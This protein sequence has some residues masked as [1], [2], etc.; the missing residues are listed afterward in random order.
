MNKVSII[1]PVYKVEQY[2]ARCVDSI[3]KQTY[4]NIEIILVDDGSPDNSGKICDELAMT[5][6]RISVIHKDNGGLS[7]ARLAGFKVATGRYIQFVDSDDFIEPTMTENLVEAMEKKNAD[8]CFC[9]YNT[10]HGSHTTPTLLPYQEE[11]ITGTQDILQQYILPL[12]GNGGQG[13]I[14]IP[15]FTCI[16]L[17]KKELLDDTHFQSERIYFLEDHILNLLY[18][19]KVHSIAI[20]NKPL[21]NYC[22]NF[23]SLSNCYRKNKW[24]MYCN[25]LKWYDEYIRVNGIKGAD[26]RLHNFKISALCATVDNAVNTGSFS[27]F[28][29]EI[30]SLY[31]DCSF[32][33]TLKQA[34]F[35]FKPDS[36]SL[37]INMLKLHMLK[38]LYKFRFNRIMK[39]KQQ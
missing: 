12:F 24:Q 23:T 34:P 37:T 2:L 3:V 20:V 16:R 14:S 5:D 27:S 18:V 17:Y 36:Q 11:L 8:L 13:E 35:R 4:K 33:R 25:I 22:V 6:D 30:M 31:S 28:T 38:S 1:V 32:K 9:G 15:G 39:S 10:I 21:Y 7:S 19:T 29:D 26:H